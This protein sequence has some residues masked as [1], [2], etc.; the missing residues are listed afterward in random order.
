MNTN[1]PTECTAWAKLASLAQA[2]AS[3]RLAD[4][5]AADAARGTQ[6]VACAPGLRL[7]Y[8][9][10]RL[11]SAILALLEKLAE[12]RGLPA[13]RSALLSGAAVN[14][15][16]RRAA[17]H[18]ALRAGE[19]APPEVNRILRQA[20]SRAQPR[21]RDLSI[22]PKSLEIDAES[23]VCSM[24]CCRLRPALPPLP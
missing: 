22:D 12:E 17:W 2:R 16:E 14:T 10:Q 1:P 9:R 18:T 4:L 6:Y 13:W 21:R 5:F 20:R 19:A 7:D 23:A 8:S 3:A 11:D 15:S 24:A